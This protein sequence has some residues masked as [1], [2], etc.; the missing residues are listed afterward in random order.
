[1]PT[2]LPSRATIKCVRSIIYLKLFKFAASPY[3]SGI[4][5]GASLYIHWMSV[6]IVLPVSY[7]S[8]L[9]YF[10]FRNGSVFGDKIGVLHVT[11]VSAKIPLDIYV[12]SLFSTL[13]KWNYCDHLLSMT[14]V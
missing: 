3:A 11:A 4:D 1:M 5:N 10:P 7:F 8:R 12:G 2:K 13:F 9:V 14:I 6:M